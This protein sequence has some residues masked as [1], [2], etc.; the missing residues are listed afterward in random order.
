MKTDIERPPCIHKFKKN[1]TEL[2]EIN[3]FKFQKKYCTVINF[4]GLTLPVFCLFYST[5]ILVQFLNCERCIFV[6]VEYKQPSSNTVI[7]IN[8]NNTT[9]IN[10]FPT[11]KK[12]KT[13]S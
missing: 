4:F 3:D 2:S 13:R 9:K 8:F 11:K 12:K 7:F 6:F 5:L 1:N 10:T